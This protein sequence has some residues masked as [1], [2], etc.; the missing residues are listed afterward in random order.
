M[1]K[2]LILLACCAL[3]TNIPP[4]IAEACFNKDLAR[5]CISGGGAWL[6]N[7]E[8]GGCHCEITKESC[9]LKNGTWY[10]TARTCSFRRV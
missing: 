7:P 2:I 3:I 9:E 4:I 6:G 10:P 1:K 5:Q 8:T